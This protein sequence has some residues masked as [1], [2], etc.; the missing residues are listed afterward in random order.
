MRSFAFRSLI[1]SVILITPITAMAVDADGD[2]H[3]ASVDCDDS[4]PAVFPGATETCNGIDDNCDGVIDDASAVDAST[5]Y[6]DTDSDG[7]GTP[8]VS[9]RACSQPSGYVSDD[10]DCNDDEATVNPAATEVCDTL[11]ND[12]DGTSDEDDAVDAVTWHPDHDLDGYGE[13]AGDTVEACDQPSGYSVN[14]LDC[15]DYH[16]TIYPGAPEDCSNGV[17][18]D[19]DGDVDEDCDTGLSEPK[20][21]AS[22][23]APATLTL[24][25]PLALLGLARRRR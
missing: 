25:L 3:D 17:D 18:D 19:C 24:L 7:Y 13:Y 12:C 6:A 21:C 23:S 11:D 22:A 2:G 10:T 9:I 16:N 15:D 4:D 1:I 14:N 5:W 20:E 8:V